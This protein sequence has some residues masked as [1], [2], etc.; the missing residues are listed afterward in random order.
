MFPFWLHSL[1]VVS[2]LVGAASALVLIV[3][4]KRYPQHIW[5]MNIVWPLTGLYTGL[6]G[7]WGYF[8][9]GRHRGGH[10]ADKPFFASVGMGDTHCGAGCML[11][12]IISE[13]TAFL[14]P[15]VVALFGYQAIFRERLFAVW[16]MDFVFALIFGIGFQYF[17]ISRARGPSVRD[18]IIAALKSDTL[19]VTT[20]QIGMYSF[21]AFAYFFFFGV[22]IGKKPAVNT[23]EF[24]FMMQMAM[25]A[26]FVSAYPM[27][28]WLIKVG[29]KE[30]M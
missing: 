8:L 11:G 6:L 29:I 14:L 30:R 9:F 12:D 16:V 4:V 3:D 2:L 26:G 10:H 27:T 28:W 22:V 7:L 21:V 20:W 5:I 19:T 24:W 25:L 18:R 17:T 15:A 23:P 13:W 1:A